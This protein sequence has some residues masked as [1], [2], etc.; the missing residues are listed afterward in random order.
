MSL[1]QIEHVTKTY[2]SR[3]KKTL[4]NDDVSLSVNEGEVF[5]LFGH[6]GAGKTT[7]VNQMLGLLTPDSGS[8]HI[9]GEDIVAKRKRGRFLCSVQPQAKTPLGELTPRHAMRI[10]AQLRG[11]SP[12]AIKRRSDELLEKL[13]IGQ[14]A[15]TEG[16]KLSGGVTRLTGFCMAAMAPGRAV[17]LDEPTNDVDPVRRRYLWSAIRELTADGTSVL[18]VTHSIREAE[19]AV[20]RIA[21]LDQGR[22]L[23]QGDARSIKADAGHNQM[24]LVA[25]LVRADAPIET[26]AWAHEVQTKD[27]EL[28]ITF[29]R[30]AATDAVALGASLYEDHI[31]GDYALT[32]ITL[33]DIYVDLLTNN[34]DA[35]AKETA[36]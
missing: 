10:M 28:V 4:A 27:A 26:P 19:S 32:E 3:G 18:L 2:Q 13:D 34:D 7:L 33:E 25:P 15:D 35:M 9:A 24:K 5:G 16:N 31:I 17:I 29:P 1:I 11:M 20:D 36:K 22:V 14:W 30:E 23:A 8:I 6:N 12:D 21:I